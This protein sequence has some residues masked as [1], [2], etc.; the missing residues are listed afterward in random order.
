M[1]YIEYFIPAILAFVF[2]TILA[3]LM[4]PFLHRLKF[5]QSIREEGPKW[6]KSKS[7]T[8]TM[9]GIIFI[10]PAVVAALCGVVVF[11]D[12][13]KAFVVM[14]TALSFG[15]VGFADDYIKVVKKRNLGLTSKQKMVLQIICTVA[16][17]ASIT[18]SR[19]ISTELY[20]PFA[21][22]RIEL[23]VFYYLFAIFA[24]TAMVNAVNLTDGI[25]GLATGVTI[26]ALTALTVFA[27]I[28]GQ[29]SIALSMIV[30][31][32]SLCGFFIF[33]KNPAKVFM[34]DTGSLFLGG[35]IAACVFEMNVP[36]LFLFVGFMYTVETVSVS[37][38]VLYF[39]ATHG[40]RLFKM[41]PI[42]HHFELCGW[43]ENK[44]VA[45]FTTITA[46]MSII[47]VIGFMNCM[48]V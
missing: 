9:G 18:L 30:L 6:H 37:L 43:N 45:V 28:V 44:I 24:I 20:I 31:A 32:T 29:K 19:D 22:L 25:D 5:G 3:K 7:G 23:G 26:V 34:G 21:G 8:P 17:L 47:G 42:H 38:Q 15:I 2:T 12:R 39:K 41:S 13:N 16:F 14:A 27:L 10:I 48:S 46:L 35:F 33:N 36:I 1:K 4:I 40:K 11:P